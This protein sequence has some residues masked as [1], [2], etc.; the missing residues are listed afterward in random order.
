MVLNMFYNK[1]GDSI[2]TIIIDLDGVVWRLNELIFGARD[3]ITTLRNEGYKIVFLT[4]NSGMSR[5]QILT[6]LNSVNIVA[7]IDE[8]LSSPNTT[9]QYVS[10]LSPQAKILMIGSAGLKTEIL[11]AG[12]TVTDNPLEADFLIAGFDNSLS[13]EKLEKALQALLNGAGFIAT[14]DDGMLPTETGYRPGAG[15]IIGAITGMIKRPPDVI[16]GKPNEVII[17]QALKNMGVVI[18]RAVIVGDSLGTDVQLAKNIGMRS[19]LVL[20]GN[21]RSLNEIETSNNIP[22]FIINSLADLP[23]LLMKAE[24]DS[25]N[26]AAVTIQH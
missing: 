5:Q 12:L 3:A 17:R 10:S 11:N 6:K 22:D 8:I 24:T 18:P 16:V 21:T 20:T 13:Y 23:N 14:N 4:N 7:S 26:F 1:L 25:E 9:A 15:A 2:E 19:I